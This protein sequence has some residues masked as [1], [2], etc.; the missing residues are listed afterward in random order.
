MHRAECFWYKFVFLIEVLSQLHCIRTSGVYLLTKNKPVLGL[1]SGFTA[2]RLNNDI[3]WRTCIKRSLKRTS[4]KIN[5][6]GTK[7]ITTSNLITTD[8]LLP[9]V[10]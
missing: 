3:L 7:Y 5:R 1:F 2:L 10:R 9:I 8:L 4:N 6:F